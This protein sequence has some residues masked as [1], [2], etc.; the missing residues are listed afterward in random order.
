MP[1]VDLDHATLH[2]TET[3]PDTGRPVV[4]VH[5]YAMGG[6]LWRGLADRLAA[7]GLRCL[8]PTWPLGAHT[9]ALRPGAD[10]TLP[11]VAATIGAF[12][13]ALDL[14]DVV[15]VGND[16]GGL[17]SQLVAVHHGERLGALV[18]TSCDAF[19][20][21]PPPVLRPFL[22]AA[23]SAT[24]WRAATKPLAL[25]VVRR[26]AYG[27][28]AHADVEPL[29]AG[30]VRP[31]LDDPGVAEDLRRLTAS[32]DRQTSLDVAARLGEVAV[33]ALVAWSA[34]D[35]FFPLDDAHRLVA[36]MPRAELRVLQGA[37]TFSMLD[38]PDELAEAIAGV[39][40]RV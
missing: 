4:F 1:T 40:V 38:R 3:G 15:L 34:D 31:V 9:T 6:D 24:T 27:G 32:L 25:E 39:A 18:L 37:R 8:A 13:D 29:A 2:Y 22:L 19:E 21:F 20:H 14:G 10:P 11:G 26:R 36:A 7:R 5:G 30:W 28:L 23:R 35:A 12:L 16:T 33:P 17:V